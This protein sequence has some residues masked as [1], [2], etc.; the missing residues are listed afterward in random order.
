LKLIETSQITD[1]R[2]LNLFRTRYTDRRGAERT[3]VFASRRSQPLSLGVVPEV[4]DAVV[5]V[6][7]HTA[8][9]ELVAIREFRVT[10]GGYQIGFPAGLIDPGE[11]ID[12][13]ARRELFEE[14]GL[15]MQRVLYRSPPVYSSSGMTDES[16]SLVFVACDGRP[17]TAANESSE[18][19]HVLFLDRAAAR[20]LD[21]DTSLKLDVKAWTIIAAFG[22]GFDFFPTR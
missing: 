3:W 18:D 1:L 6:P 17:S 2:H 9:Q 7:F 16:V 19:I 8:R 20:H 14:T 21:G 10:L 15:K 13:A 11:T 22:C 4:P 5:I 12:D